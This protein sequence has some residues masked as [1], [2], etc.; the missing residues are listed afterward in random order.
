MA[1]ACEL[2]GNHPRAELCLRRAVELEPASASLR[3]GLAL[4]QQLQGKARNA[5]EN[6]ALVFRLRPGDRGTSNNVAWIRATHPDEQFRD[7]VKAIDLLQPLAAKP[8]SD[9]NLL[10]T[11]AAAYAEAGRFDDALQ[12]IQTAIEQART[13]GKVA[14]NDRRLP[15]AG[16]PL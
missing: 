7:G 12:T 15:T 2:Q 16:S 5:L 8:D 3:Y 10:D 13:E 9:A 6:Y 4:T 1:H 11:L 14:G